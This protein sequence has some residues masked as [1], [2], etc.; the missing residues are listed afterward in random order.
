MYNYTIAL[1]ICN[2]IDSVTYMV[3]APSIL[4]YVREN[5]GNKEEYGYILSSFSFSCFIFKYFFGSWSD[6]TG[7]RILFMGSF[8]LSII[9][10]ALYTVSCLFGDYA[11]L[12]ILSS[13]LLMGIGAANSVLTYCYVARVVP[14]EQQTFINTLLGFGKIIGMAGGPAFNV[15]LVYVNIDFGV[16]VLDPLNSVGVLIML[17]N[18]VS[19]ISIYFLLE[20]PD[21][22]LRKK[23]PRS[24]LLDDKM[25]T[26]SEVKKN[27][28]KASWIEIISAIL[29][30]NIIVPFCSLFAFNATFQLVETGL[31]PAM[32]DG[33]GWKTKKI[34]GVFG[35]LSI[36]IAVGMAIVSALSKRNISDEVL[37]RIGLMLSVIASSL[38]Y[39]LWERHAS[40]LD[41]CIPLVVGA[42]SFPFLMVPART[43]FTL[44]VDS[45]PALESYQ[46]TMQA[47]LSMGG[48]VAGFTI[49]AFVAKYCV[50][51]PKQVDVSVPQR[52][53]TEYSLAFPVLCALTLIG[54][55]LMPEEDVDLEL[56]NPAE[57][58]PEQQ[59]ID[60]NTP[61][62][63]RK[64][65][66][67]VSCRARSSS[68]SRSHSSS[69]GRS[70]SFPFPN[71]RRKSHSAE[72][73]N[74]S[75]FVIMGIHQT[76][77]EFVDLPP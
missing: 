43:I 7:L 3:I 18:F 42:F 8:L 71:L 56:P 61:F 34:S 74:E 77:D 59:P 32:S 55:M 6:R 60:E 38:L 65:T 23:Y 33:L 24:Y 4:F 69:G 75:T 20:E 15:L 51:S 9:G 21:V 40:L 35:S 52:E 45:K 54:A 12:G 57:V 72:A 58:I 22:F 11:I 46:G 17:L 63:I 26:I 47:A 19:M 2:L 64:I 1:V 5:G 25:D 39:L 66:P 37:L 76:A 31:T 30:P 13:R 10:G 16:F 48:S 70:K 53:M 62:L 49:P 68:W 50:K 36:M 73:V 27:G 29:C 41:F 28:N 44:A 67:H 14:H